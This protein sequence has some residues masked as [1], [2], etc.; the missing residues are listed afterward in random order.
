MSGRNDT[1]GV[2]GVYACKLDMLH[3]GRNEGMCAITDSICFTF[4][5]VIQETVNQNGSVGGYAN[6]GIHV[7]CQIFGAIHDFHTAAAQN[8][9][10]ANHN[11]IA[12]FF[13]DMKGIRNRNCH[14]GFGHGNTKLIHHCTEVVSVFCQV[15]HSR[16]SPQ[17]FYAVLFQISRQIQ[18]SLTAEL[19]DNANGLFF[20]INAQHIFQC[21]RFKVKLI[22]GVIVCGNG[23][24]VAVYDNCFKTKLL[25]RQRSMYAAVVKFNTLPDSVGAAAQNHNLGLFCADGVFVLCIIGGVVIRLILC[26]ADM[27]GLPSLLQTQRDALVSDFCFIDFQKLAQIFIGEAILLC[28]NQYIIRRQLSFICQK[29]FLLLNQLL[30]LIDEP[31]LYLC[32][33][34]DFFHGCALAQCFIHDEMAFTGGGNQHFQKFFL[35]FFIKILCMPQTIATCF[36]RTD[37]FL[38]G[39]FIILTDTHNLAD[40]AHLGTQLI[41]YAFEFFKCPACEFDNNII[42]IG[43]IFIQCAV[44]TAGDILQSQPCCKH[45][46]NQSNGEAGCLGSQCGGTG[47][48]GVDFD[49][50]ISVCFGVMRPLY[51]C[52]ADYLYGIDNLIG[53]FLQTLLYLLGNSQHGSGAEGITGMHTK[54]VDIFNKAYGN[55]IAFGI[56]H[57]LQFQLFPA[58]YGFFYK[59]LSDKTCL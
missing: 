13:C 12:D 58:E 16:R 56:T 41:L 9:G 8:I 6:S 25:Q 21:Q 57:N 3:N 50:D 26:A 23:F 29:G 2:T 55:H 37:G 48:S 51:V 32:Q 7:F 42:A 34:M 59:H 28:G 4:H 15:D 49:D 1:C 22:G 20:F 45:G 54:G 47:G 44:F 46:G 19:R 18:R 31:C 43:N 14:A 11:G 24:G 39:F 35:G 17:N 53:F 36:Q 10:G 52:A 33:L 27:N 38:E 40:C 30:H 5:C